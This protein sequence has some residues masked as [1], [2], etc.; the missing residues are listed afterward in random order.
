MG[1]F[2]PTGSDQRLAYET[3]IHGF[4]VWGSAF[5]DG[6]EREN[7][8]ADYQLFKHLDGADEINSLPS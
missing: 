8:G 1:L 2:N 5:R 6:G 4:P 3:C 7:G